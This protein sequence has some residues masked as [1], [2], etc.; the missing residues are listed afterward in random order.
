MAICGGVGL[1]EGWGS[2]S[3]VGWI[4]AICLGPQRARDLWETATYGTSVAEFSLAVPNERLGMLEYKFTYEYNHGLCQDIFLSRPTGP[5]DKLRYR[6]YHVLF[7]FRLLYLPSVGAVLTMSVSDLSWQRMY[8]DIIS[9]HSTL[10][11]CQTLD[12]YSNF[13]FIWVN[14][15]WI[16]F[17]NLVYR[18]VL[19]I[20][21]I[22]HLCICTTHIS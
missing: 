19:F 8:R 15:D 1:T 9:D 3:C 11:P 20:N 5:S 21:P 6:W 14:I 12:I 13:V 7:S 18:P 22:D 16:S 4:S 10:N 17:E 2:K